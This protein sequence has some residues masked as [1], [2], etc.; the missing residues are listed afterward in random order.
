MCCQQPND[1]DCGVYACMNM[2]HLVYG[3]AVP[4]GYEYR[5]SIAKMRALVASRILECCEGKTPK[6]LK[7]MRLRPTAGVPDPPAERV[8]LE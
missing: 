4:T 3:A 2:L 1:V 6:P 5:N 8:V 7:R